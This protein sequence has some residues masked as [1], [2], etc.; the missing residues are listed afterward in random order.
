MAC[1][2]PAR[3]SPVADQGH[4]RSPVPAHGPYA[5]PEGWV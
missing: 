4:P 3:M 5:G 2:G 1:G